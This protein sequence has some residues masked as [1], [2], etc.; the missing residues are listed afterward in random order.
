[1]V[2]QIYRAN[3][4]D[5]C[6]N[7][8]V[9]NI[10]IIADCGHYDIQYY[11]WH[12]RMIDM[13]CKKLMKLATGLSITNRIDLVIGLARIPE[14]KCETEKTDDDGNKYESTS[15]GPI[16][17][18]MKVINK[19]MEGISAEQFS[20]RSWKLY[21]DDD[22]CQIGNIYV[23][24]DDDSTAEMLFHYLRKSGKDI[25]PESV[26]QELGQITKTIVLDK[27]ES[28]GFILNETSL[29][30]GYTKIEISCISITRNMKIPS[31]ASVWQTIPIY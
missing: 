3:V 4:D 7:E 19:C 23:L 5:L 18:I 25:S 20:F 8:L 22:F 13:Q 1:M 11:P 12:T 17:E 24:D 31:S 6:V 16:A 2:D 26:R 21:F 15:S 9:Q 30:S 29:Q 14:A 10:N 27:Q 28:K